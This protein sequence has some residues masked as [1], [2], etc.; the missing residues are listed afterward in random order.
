LG[1]ERLSKTSSAN[2][3]REVWQLS[4][5]K[6]RLSVEGRAA[7]AEGQRVRRKGGRGGRG[8]E[9][10]GRDGRKEEWREKRRK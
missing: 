7:E 9:T 6:V 10:E 8:S 1:L 2:P 3:F 5:L 4:D